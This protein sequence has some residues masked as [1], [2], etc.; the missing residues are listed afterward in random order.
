MWLKQHHKRSK[1]VWL[2]F[3]KKGAQTPNLSWSEA[4]EEA[5]CFGWIDGVR[6]TID[7]DRFK[8]YFT[9][10]KPKSNWSRINKEKVEQLIATGQM[11]PAGLHSIKIAKQNG[12]WTFLDDVEALV[13]PSDLEAAFDNTTKI[14]FHEL[15][16]SVKK[17]HLYELLSAKQP[18]TRQKRIE[19]II[20]SL[21]SSK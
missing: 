15:S 19:K 17:L 10:R 3:Y 2:I 20:T 6:N 16:K 8:Q 4:V 13:I 18:T 7:A 1:C 21:K 9:K 12:S 14:R 5:L 11:T